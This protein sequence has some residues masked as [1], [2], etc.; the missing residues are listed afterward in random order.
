MFRRYIIGDIESVV[1]DNTDNEENKRINKEKGERRIV[2]AK[3]V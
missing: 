1:D 3:A 2:R